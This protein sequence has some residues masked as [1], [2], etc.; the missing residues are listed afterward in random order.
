LQ[1]RQFRPKMVAIRDASKVGALKEAIRDVQPQPEILV[2]DAGTIEV[3]R[4]PDIDAVVTG[5]VGKSDC[6]CLGLI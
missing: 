5:I 4:H 6:M 2:G 3:A 1:I